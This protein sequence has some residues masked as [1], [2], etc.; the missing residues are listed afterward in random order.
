MN[1]I[2]PKDFSKIKNNSDIFLLDV[3]TQEEWNIVNIGGHLIPMAE[4]YDRINEVPQDKQIVVLC[5]HGIRSAQVASFLLTRDFSEVQNLL[6]GI[7]RYA[8]EVDKNLQK[9]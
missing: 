2:T 3:R 8:I 7:D 4:I 1:S 6:G 5:H 9:Y